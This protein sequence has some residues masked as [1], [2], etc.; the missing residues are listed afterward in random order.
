M[1]ES[2]MVRQ[3]LAAVAALCLVAA[4]GM[5]PPKRSDAVFDSIPTGATMEQVRDRLGKPDEEMAFPATRTTSWT[6]F[7]YDTWGFYAEE[8]LTFDESGRLARKFSNR[9]GYGGSGKQ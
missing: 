8:S 9:V 7:Y 3:A 6:Y 4:C 5:Q 2:K 1:S